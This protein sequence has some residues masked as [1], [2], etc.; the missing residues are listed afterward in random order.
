MY[1]KRDVLVTLVTYLP[2]VNHAF[3]CS[4][5]FHLLEPNMCPPLLLLPSWILPGRPNI[6]EHSD[7]GFHSHNNKVDGLSFTTWVK[8]LSF[9]KCAQ[10][11]Y[12]T[13]VPIGI[14]KNKTDVPFVGKSLS[15]SHDTAQ[16]RNY[17][18]SNIFNVAKAHQKQEILRRLFRK[19]YTSHLLSWPVKRYLC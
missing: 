4:Q 15:K 8:L 11:K 19:K 10:K 12:S 17:H 2:T 7:G 13:T 16:S 18:A 14:R 6:V 9:Q 1:F 5:T 3:S